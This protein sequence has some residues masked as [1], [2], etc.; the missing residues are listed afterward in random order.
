MNHQPTITNIIT[1]SLFKIVNYLAFITQIKY[2]TKS[3]DMDRLDYI[4]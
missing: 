2:S 4:F 3:F 1:I